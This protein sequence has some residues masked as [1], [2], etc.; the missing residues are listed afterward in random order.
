MNRAKY[1]KSRK[2]FLVLSIGAAAIIFAASAITPYSPAK[3]QSPVAVS[4]YSI[5][6]FASSIPG[7]FT[8]PGAIA[9][10][11][12]SVYIAYSNGAAPDGSNGS[13]TIVQY[14][15]TGAMG[16]TYTVPGANATLKVDPQT[17]HLWALQNPVANPSLTTIDPFA[18]NPANAE[19]HF[20]FAPTAHG[21]GYGDLAFLAG[22][23]YISASNPSAN[24]NT[25]PAI[26]ILSTTLSPTGNTANVVPVLSGTTSATDSVTGSVVGLNIQSPL[27]LV[28]DPVNDLVLNDQADSQLIFV[29]HPSVPDQTVY[30]T[31]LKLNGDPVE[32]GNTVFTTTPNGMLLVSDP[33][34]E[35]VY[36]IT[37]AFFS[38]GKV[39][40]TGAGQVAKVDLDSGGLTTLVTGLATP[41]RL[42]FIENSDFRLTFTPNEVSLTGG[43]TA[44]TIVQTNRGGPIS[45]NITVAL[46]DGFSLAKGFK[47]STATPLTLSGATAVLEM[48]VKASA[49]GIVGIPFT[50]TDSSGRIRRAALVINNSQ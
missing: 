22:D 31:Q 38:T 15:T 47:F 12:D 10:T 13:T 40:T 24:P 2:T 23:V 45:G 50:A 20:S 7:Q 46:Q 3:A 4:P 37:R 11:N 35:T 17:G 1:P 6:V 48:K 30:R 25:A 21:G 41:T 16:N 49:T 39:Y 32:I 19:T 8:Q 36:A 42:A 44:L 26:L 33:G 9:F 18:A 43:G 29:N 5:S 28:F 27:S 14:S 34:A